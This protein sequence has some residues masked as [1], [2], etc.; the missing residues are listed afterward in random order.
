M[1]FV[2]SGGWIARF[3]SADQHHDAAV[4]W[5]R[6]NK[7]SLFITDYIVDEALTVLKARGEPRLAIKL[8][9]LFFGGGLADIYYL[10]EDDIRAA[11]QVFRTYTDK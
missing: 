2:D 7:Q 6:Q 5:F 8:G 1:I 10:T 11:W 9:E 3:Y 4:R